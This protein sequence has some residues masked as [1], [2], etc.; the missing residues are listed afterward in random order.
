MVYFRFFFFSLQKKIYGFF[1]QCKVVK[2]WC[3]VQMLCTVTQ[4]LHVVQTTAS[5]FEGQIRQKMATE[6]SE[7]LEQI[8]SLEA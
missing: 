6:K 3:T 8:T 2:K 4:T 5:V 1:L 7:V